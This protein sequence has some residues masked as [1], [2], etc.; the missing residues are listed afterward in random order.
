[1]FLAEWEVS[2]FLC[3]L[4]GGADGDAHTT[5]ARMLTLRIDEVKDPGA[6]GA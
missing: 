1:M 5:P 4:E 2:R 3:Q 6:S